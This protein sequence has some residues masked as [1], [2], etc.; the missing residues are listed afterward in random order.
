MDSFYQW[1]NNIRSCRNFK[2]F[3]LAIK[4]HNFN[5]LSFTQSVNP[6]SAIHSPSMPFDFSIFANTYRSGSDLHIIMY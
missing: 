2:I 6:N 3:L 5:N 4:I 1:N